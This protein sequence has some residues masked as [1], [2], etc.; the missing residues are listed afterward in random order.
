MG[1][2]E[3]GFEV[4]ML[5]ELGH[6]HVKWQAFLL[7]ALNLQILLSTVTPYFLYHGLGVFLV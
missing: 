1:L 7:T 3:V 5:M 6:C 4:G 2:W